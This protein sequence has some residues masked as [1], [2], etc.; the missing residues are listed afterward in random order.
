MQ[1]KKINTTFVADNQ[2]LMTIPNILAILYDQKE[3]IK[4]LLS[5]PLCTRTEERELELASPL[6]QVVIGVRRSGKST[7]CMKF[8][9]EHDIDFAYINF[10][11]DRLHNVATA[12]LNDILN[13]LYQVYGDFKYLFIDEVQ[14]VDGWQLFVNRLLRHR[15]HIFITGSNSKLLS[16][17][18]ATH[19]TGRHRRIE[20]FP[21]SYAEYCAAIKVDVKSKTTKA[22]AL[23]QK[24]L[25]DYLYNGGFPE[26]LHT[27]HKRA[28]INT[29]L[30]SIIKNDIAGRFRVRHVDVLAKLANYLA[31]NF[32]QEFRPQEVAALLGVTAP[33]IST[34]YSYLKEA[35]LLLGI[36]KFSYKSSERIRNEKVYVVDTAFIQHRENTFSTQNLGWRLENMVYIE[37]LRRYRPKH[38][39]VFYYRC[40][41]WEVDFVVADSGRVIKLIQVSYDI[42][43]EKTLKRELRGLVN[44][45]EKFGCGDLQL[46][47]ADRRETISIGDKTIHVVKGCEWLMEAEAAE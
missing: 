5:E 34:Y 29:L 43:S 18:L 12:D 3:D 6:A 44:A 2:C 17:E 35:F 4:T 38:I 19:L 15:M 39:D 24:A 45:S 9:Y 21:F 47:T 13:A 33:T 30:D 31:D 25:L 28:Y 27:A 41:Q 14:N 1:N 26:L 8:L 20:M 37:L 36:H 46:I 42:S 7:L 10:D 11:D 40:S 23:R 16:N 32:C 22:E